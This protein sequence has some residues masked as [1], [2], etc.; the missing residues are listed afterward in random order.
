MDQ[1]HPKLC[2]ALV[3]AGYISSIHVE[4]LARCRDV[5]VVALC[6]PA[7]PRARS[8]A[9]R[10]G[11]ARVHGSIGELLEAGGI[12]AAHVLVPP[13]RHREVAEQLLRAGVHTLVEKPL[14]LTSGD[15]A[16]L[17]D[18]AAEH[19]AAVGVNHNMLFHPRVRT[20]LADVAG[21]AIGRLEHLDLVHNVPLRQL[22]SGDTSHF[23]F[24][25]EAAILLEQA[26]HPLSIVQRLLGRCV[27]VTTRLEPPRRLPTGA[28]FYDTWSIA[29]RC[30]RGTAQLTLAFGRAFSEMS[31]HAIGTDGSA[32]VD[33]VRSTYSKVEK[34]K[35]LEFWDIALNSM[36]AGAGLLTQ[37]FASAA[38]YGL[39]LFG[40]R[41]L[42]DA[43]LRSMGD[44]VLG[45][46]EA[47]RAGREL[48]CS[49]E[50]A[51]QVI[52]MCERI[53][54]AAGVSWAKHPPFEP[55][56]QPPAPRPGEVVVTGATGFL[57]RSVV[58]MLRAEGR[59]VTV[60]V[61]R[62]EYTPEFLRDPDIR[63]LVGDA[64]DSTAVQRAVQGASA[65]LHMATCA[66]GPGEKVED[67]MIAGARAVGEA[68]LDAGVERLVFVSSTAALYLGGSESVKGSVGPDP[69][70]SRRA[71][72]SRG[73]IAAEQELGRLARERGL[74]L[75][76]M[77]PAIVVGE[78]GVL[79]HSGVGLWVR[80][81]HCVGWGMGRHPLPFVLVRDCARALV[82]SVSAPGVLG[83]SYNLAGDV[84]PSAVDYVREMRRRTGR[85]FHFHGQP[86][87]LIMA[88]EIGKW[89]IKV[90][91][92]RPRELPS[93][94]DFRSRGF[95]AQLDC[96]DAKLELGWQP[97]ADAARFYDE[98]L[99]MPRPVPAPVAPAPR[100]ADAG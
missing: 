87:W 72:Y 93:A 80:D 89:L 15:V 81:N 35:W 98:A 3:G 54:D 8:L 32:R 31:V 33:L 48:P 9:K 65:V 28:L 77:R 63:V 99:P 22:D 97:E 43:Y 84:R 19:G 24:G 78:G 41:K 92:R 90:A 20:L 34:T 11:I 18:V 4:A 56:L 59:P 95:T 100:A 76:I 85:D 55:P 73:K 10:F 23:M 38:H 5:E 21:G 37:G 66:A 17:A 40:L 36:R 30:E 12:D 86:I 67:S 75:V 26:V 25:S 71:E 57:G 82:A 74:P 16:A 14:A 70:P 39:G 45:F 6:D 53:A 47:L 58:P 69:R 91:A 2:V 49:A 46:Y 7:L 94:R 52:E 79:N 60:L 29:M 51:R 68:C 61:R 50:G 62:P 1:D 64:R 27:D 88:V 83:K 42:P 44:S 96:H 13:D